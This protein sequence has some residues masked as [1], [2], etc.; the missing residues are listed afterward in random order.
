MQK[1]TCKLVQ[2][3]SCLILFLLHPLPLLKGIF[4][5]SLIL[6][7]FLAATGCVLGGVI[8][9][10]P[11]TGVEPRVLQGGVGVVV[12][13]VVHGDQGLLVVNPAVG[14]GEMVVGH[15][16]MVRIMVGFLVGVMVGFLMGL[17]VMAMRVTISV[18]KFASFLGRSLFW[19][20]CSS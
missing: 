8:H 3:T 6:F 18:L 10:L 20:R 2:F 16:S 9:Q 1:S 5:L 7:L 15:S 14:D 11:L 19:L 17:N 13:L 4:L 12:R